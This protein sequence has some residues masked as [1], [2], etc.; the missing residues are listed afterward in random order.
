MASWRTV[1][2]G[3]RPAMSGRTVRLRRSRWASASGR[4]SSQMASRPR[5]RSQRLRGSTTVPPPVAITRRTRR[6]GSAATE[7]RDGHGLPPPE[8]RLALGLE[9]RRDRPAGLPSRSSSSRSMNVGAVAVGEA[10]AD[11]GLAAAGQPDEDDVHRPLSRPRRSRPRR[12]RRA[13]RATA[14]SP[15]GRGDPGSGS[16]RRCRRTRPSSRRRTCRGRSR[17]G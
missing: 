14:A 8:P 15:R 1:P 16:A 5:E 12:S 4:P 10:A 11:R 7:R 3:S 2:I 6:S 17:P 13:G 9:D